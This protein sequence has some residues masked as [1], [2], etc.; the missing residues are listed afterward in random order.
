MRIRN[1]ES[2][3]RCSCNCGCVSIDCIFLNSVSDSFT[4]AVY[5]Q[6]CESALP[7]VVCAE[8]QR[9]SG[10]CRS[11]CVKLHLYIIRPDSVVVA[12]VIPCLRYGNACLLLGV[13]VGNRHTVCRYRLGIA[14]RYRNFICCIYNFCCSCRILRQICELR[15]PAVICI[16]SYRRS[17]SNTVCIELNLYA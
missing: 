16:E 12:V 8:R 2:V 9:L 14:C 7:A 5:R 3:F 13:C 1:S 4:I 17:V 6:I 15:R 11:V 10:Y